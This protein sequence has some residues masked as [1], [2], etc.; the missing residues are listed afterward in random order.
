MKWLIIYSAW[1]R[2]TPPESMSGYARRSASTR[3]SAESISRISVALMINLQCRPRTWSCRLFYI[4]WHRKAEE[5]P[6]SAT[7]EGMDDFFEIS[8]SFLPSNRASAREGQGWLS[9]WFSQAPP[10]SLPWFREP[11]LVPLPC[12]LPS[13]FYWQRFTTLVKSVILFHGPK[14]NCQGD[15]VD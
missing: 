14:T 11:Y 4:P 5:A 1:E 8:L 10:P 3:K 9:R 6:I 12:H 15:N 13:F 7:R 2:R